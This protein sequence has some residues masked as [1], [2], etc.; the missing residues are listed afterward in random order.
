MLLDLLLILLIIIF[1]LEKPSSNLEPMVGQPLE[2]VKSC[3]PQTGYKVYHPHKGF[4]RPRDDI[5]GKMDQWCRWEKDKPDFIR[6]L[7]QF[8]HENLW[9][10]K[11]GPPTGGFPPYHMWGARPFHYPRFIPKTTH[12]VTY[13]DYV[14][15]IGGP[16][17]RLPCYPETIKP[18][19]PLD[20]LR[21]DQVVCELEDSCVPW[22]NIPDPQSDTQV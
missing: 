4:P 22:Q 13:A 7:D 2:E 21:I 11:G 12:S 14:T 9:T 1:F 6:S 20:Q 3:L 16:Y 18:Q 19:D 8:V 5:R 17:H 15:Q 10:G